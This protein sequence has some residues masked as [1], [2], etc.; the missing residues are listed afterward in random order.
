MAWGRLARNLDPVRDLVDRDRQR[1]FPADFDDV[2]GYQERFVDTARVFEL[3]V[4][5]CASIEPA[6]GDD[7]VAIVV[8][9]WFGTP[10]PWSAIA[11]GLGL[12]RRGRPVVF[13]WH[14]LPF[15]DPSAYFRLQDD[16][17]GRLMRQLGR[18]F[19]VIRIS[20]LPDAP[21]TGPADQALPNRLA[22]EN[23]MWLRRGGRP[24]TGDV[25]F[26]DRMRTQL[27]G[28][29]PKVREL[30]RAQQ[31]GSA[32]VCGGV[33]GASGLYLAA[34]QAVGIRVATFDA[35]V[36]AMAIDVDGVAAQHP[37]AVQAFGL[38]GAEA[39]AVRAIAIDAAQR[40][41][42]SRRSGD[43]PDNY[44]L[45]RPGGGS[46]VAPGCI[47]IPLSVIHDAAALGQHHI[48]ADARE[49]LVATIA[50]LLDE[51]TDEIVVRQHP[52]ERKAGERSS[53]DVRTILQE[54]FGS[55]PQVRLIAAEDDV[56]TYDLLDS[57]RLALPFV[58]T[59]GIEAAALGKSVIVSGSVYYAGLGFVWAPQTREDYFD[60]L[61]RGARGEL[62]LLPDQVDLAWQSYYLT[63]VCQRVWTN[64]TPQPPDFWRW[65]TRDPDEL[66]DDPDVQDILSALDEGIPLSILRHRRRGQSELSTS[67]LA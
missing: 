67:S 47:L 28:A 12:A 5:R 24:A 27:A 58:S 54:A 57:C 14:D 41:F 64:F 42:N 45:A 20:E 25:E 62:P 44:Q 6:P 33:V 9:P 59:I 4:G 19:P 37:D 39:P 55:N 23:L 21:V 51:T 65:V 34:G 56:S 46:P 2:D 49:W 60:V 8:M 32:V 52:S 35:G 3:F 63:A 26:H 17:I 66:Y 43:D 30:F 48:F 38:L 7:P 18:R 15:P 36:G 29:L 31:F 10:S 40:E 16:E 53:F 13:V 22:E 50:A 11:I 1:A 61:G